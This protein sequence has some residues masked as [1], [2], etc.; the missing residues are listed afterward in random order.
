[1]K[2][3]WS[4]RKIVTVTVVVVITAA[5]YFT[6]P[7]AYKPVAFP[8]GKKFAFAIVDD[9]DGATMEKIKPVYDYLQELG[10][11]CTKTVWVLPTNDPEHWPNRGVT[12]VDSE[13]V[14]YLLDLQSKGYEIGLHGVRGGHSTR[15]EVISGLETFKE[16]F[17]GYPRIQINHSQNYDN[18][19]WGA[20]KLSLAPLSYL[21]DLFYTGSPSYGHI[22]ES[23]YFWGDIAQ[24]HISYVV[25]FSF[26]DINTLKI[27]PLVPYHLDAQP[28]VNYWFH[29][30]DGGFVDSFNELIKKENVDRLESEGGVCFVYT[31]FASSFAVNDSINPLFRERMAYLVSKDGWF[32]PAS[33][34]L[35]Y[36]REHREG[37]DEPS[38]RERVY[39]ELRW[40]YEK[41]LHGS[42]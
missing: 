40:L 9:T 41:L 27:N 37:Q 4:W 1:M 13:Y 25:N 23:E 14:S 29:S 18:L 2:S 15:E 42:R 16:I 35:D 22:P 20:D 26:E 24:D 32:A 30:S 6:Y 39:I 31:H 8:D 34:I 3:G 19:Y 36:I 28:Y 17:G 33:E 38:F 11:R 10:I 21:Y 5:F 7:P 12:V